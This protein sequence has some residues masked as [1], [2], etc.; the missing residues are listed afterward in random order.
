MPVLKILLLPFAFF[1][2]TVIFFRN[3]FFDI[4][5]LKSKEFN[6]PVISVGNLVAG[7]TGKSPLIEYLI[8]LLKDQYKIATLSRGYG[9]KTKGFLEA[10]SLS[11]IDEV[12]DEPLQFKKKF[13]EITVAVC[14]R[15]R[16]GIEH[17][18]NTQD[19]IL[20]DDAYQHRAVK[21]GLSIL[22]YDYNSLFNQDFILPLGK[23]R[24]PGSEM[25]RA[26]VLLI[27]K[28]P[29]I[30]SPME[31]RRVEA[32][33]K[34]KENQQIFYSYIK[35]K[36]LIPL[37]PE[38]PVKTIE[39]LDKRTGVIL[40]TG[41]A[42]PLS[43]VNYIED[44]IKRKPVHLAYPDHHKFNHRD[45]SRLRQT[46]ENHPA[47]DKIIITTEKD[48]TR[49]LISKLKTEVEQ[50]PVYYLPIQAEIHKEDK[51]HFDKL[52]LDYVRS[53]KKHNGVHPSEN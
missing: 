8:L 30:F 2:A 32:R 42:N 7:G 53:N 24:E 52:I 26:D 14:E 11:T 51:E 33:L 6:L 46:F 43:L 44:L 34:P 48:S 19:V 1:Y 28:T 10:N 29:K 45:I 18:Q 21:P 41:I 4:G 37:N 5:L 27:T 40:F 12:G 31:R 36:N 39:E 50:L 38:H 22:L 16:Y 20:L 15:R 17:L 23:L 3:L 13:N 47:K 49:L 25:S 35:Y 9:R